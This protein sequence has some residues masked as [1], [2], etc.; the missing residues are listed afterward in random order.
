MVQI[1]EHSVDLEF[2]LGDGIHFLIA[3]I[4]NRLHME[5]RL[6]KLVDP[7]YQRK[8]LRS[9]MDL[10]E[11]YEPENKFH[12]IVLPESS[13]PYSHVE[14]LSEVMRDRFSP[15]TVMICGLEHITLSQYI[16]LMEGHVEENVEALELVR[17]FDSETDQAKPVNVYVTIIKERTGKIRHFFSAKTHPFAGEES[18][19]HGFDLF[20]GR[21]F[22]LFRCA[23]VCFNFMPLICFDYVYRD[24]HQSNI[25][26]IIE[27]AN[28]LYSRQ[29]QKLDLLVV[30]QCNPKPEHKVF[31]DVATG[32]YGEH[33]FK[34]PGVRET[35]TMFV[36]SSDETELAGSKNPTTFGYSSIVCGIRHRLPKIKLSEFRT[37]DF[38]GSQ[39]SRLR[40][41]P[42]TRLY[43]S[44][45]FPHHETDP[46]SSRAM[47]KV[48][49]VYHPA[50]G[51]S[52][53]RIKGD[54]L[55]V[56]IPN[57]EDSTDW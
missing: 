32:F 31:R 49:G 34:T 28:E 15:N 43:L 10:A 55:V 36:N 39:V 13:V 9:V 16:S 21:S 18:V 40:F 41:G 5:G 23:P 3:Q 25:M 35:I 19:D 17:Q 42:S 54:D 27:R 6:F 45:I 53:F 57:E 44:R 50:P 37:D 47:V 7:D 52:W 1:L 30:I 8:L 26:T 46:R 14:E 38:F 4:S 12:F 33:L 48:T 20:R 11:S 56:G 22:H 24:I 2:P 29:R 51:P